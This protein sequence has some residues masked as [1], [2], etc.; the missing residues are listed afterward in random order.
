M[1]CLVDQFATLLKKIHNTDVEPGEMPNM[2]EV[3]LTWAD[4]L[5]PYLPSESAEKLHNLIA[6]VPDVHKMIHG[7]YHTKNVMLQ[8]GEVLLIDMDTL[9]YGHPIFEFASMFLGFVG[10]GEADP[11]TAGEFLGIPYDL[12]C[13]FFEKSMEKYLGTTDKKTID[14]VVNKARI[15]GY[16][17]LMRR[18]IKRIGLNTPE[19]QPTIDLCKRNL[20]TLLPQYDT[21]TF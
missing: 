10:F 19:G 18:T 7:D 14:D 4:Y 21:L 15:I 9:S 20:L 2:K 5:K 1:D 8:K 17:R 6:A 12:S 13:Q 3:A 16:T 11:K